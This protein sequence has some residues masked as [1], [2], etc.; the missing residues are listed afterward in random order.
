M[1]NDKSAESNFCFP[2]FWHISRSKLQGHVL[3]P[4]KKKR[5]L[6]FLALSSFIIFS[7]KFHYVISVK[8]YLKNNIT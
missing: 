6:K 1:V 4:K 5:K 8:R 7:S 2:N 3:G